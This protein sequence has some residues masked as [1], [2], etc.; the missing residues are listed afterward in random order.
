MMAKYDA[1]NPQ[2]LKRLVGSGTQLKPFPRPVMDA[3]F[4][5]AQEV[6]A[7]TNAANANFKRVSDHYFNFQRDQISWF[8]VTENTF[9]DYMATAKR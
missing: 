4:R 1:L 3:C 6:Y 7:E 2:A 9:D 5:A 8:R